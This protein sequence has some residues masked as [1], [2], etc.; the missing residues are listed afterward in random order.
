MARDF[1]VPITS[2]GVV[3][4]TVS[5][6]STLT[7][8]TLTSPVVNSPTGIVKAD[9]GLA[10]VDNTS[11]AT[12]RAATATLTN[13]DLSSTTNTFPDTTKYC[14]RASA[15][16]ATTL[17]DNTLTKILVA[18]ETYDYNNDFASSTYTAP[19]GGVYH[20]D[21]NFQL[22]T[23]ISGVLIQAVLY[24]DGV[25]HTPGAVNSLISYC[26]ASISTDVLLTTGQTVD[27]YGVQESAGSE[28]TRTGTDTWFSGHLVH[29]V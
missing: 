27:F 24:V 29:K 9:V 25:R 11:N 18:S 13:K 4:P 19:F 14:F 7:N 28:D 5:S 6:T 21:G 17:P 2:G 12:E 10:N 23:V 16:A 22:S 20:F 15:S 3:I 26:G 8:K 1:K